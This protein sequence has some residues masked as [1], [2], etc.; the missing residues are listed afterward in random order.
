M[1]N[2]QPGGHNAPAGLGHDEGRRVSAD[3]SSS[4]D[5]FISYRRD[6]SSGFAR[7]LYGELSDHFG[8]DR[9]FMDVD[10]ID[11]GED[12]AAA[13]ERCVGS[14]KVADIRPDGNHLSFVL[15]R[16]PPVRGVEAGLPKTSLGRWYAAGQPVIIGAP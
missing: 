10:T 13:I 4:P 14:G 7:A 8:D 9:V 3:G 15:F 16:R 12:Y 11:P 1:T 6:D 2:A 5:I